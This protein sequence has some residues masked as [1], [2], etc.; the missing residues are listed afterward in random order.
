MSEIY[1]KIL[2]ISSLSF[3]IIGLTFFFVGHLLNSQTATISTVIEE[4]KGEI[5]AYFTFFPK[6]FP[7]DIYLPPDSDIRTIN[8]NSENYFIVFETQESESL[9]KQKFAGEM[10]K[11]GWEI[12]NNT[13]IKNNKRVSLDTVLNENQKNVVGLLKVMQKG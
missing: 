2:Q 13:F 5:A 3:L 9:L 12:Q 4:T 7:K 11:Q 6:D 1:S 8:K 10:K